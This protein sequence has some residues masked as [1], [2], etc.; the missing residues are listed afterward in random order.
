MLTPILSIIIGVEMLAAFSVT[1][2]LL[3]RADDLAAGAR[4]DFKAIKRM[5]KK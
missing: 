2:Y 4:A 5:L 1:I 3:Y